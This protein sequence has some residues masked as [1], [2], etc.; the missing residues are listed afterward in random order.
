[1]NNDRR[2]LEK[3]LR[4]T[5]GDAAAAAIRYVARDPELHP[6]YATTEEI[7]AAIAADQAEIAAWQQDLALASAPPTT[8][9]DD[10]SPANEGS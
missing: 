5:H 2:W 6:D 4:E 3:Q 10:S 7:T 1:M 8:S 9:G